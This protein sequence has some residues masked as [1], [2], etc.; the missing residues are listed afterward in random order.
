MTQ[1]ESQKQWRD[2][3]GVLKLQ[4]EKLDFN[5]LWYWADFLNIS[6]LINLAFEEAGL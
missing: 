6:E 5:Y 2:I 1:N 3:L 4:G